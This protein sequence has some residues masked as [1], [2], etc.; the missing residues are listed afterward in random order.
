MALSKL[1]LSPSQNELLAELIQLDCSGSVPSDETSA[2][3]AVSSHPP[4]TPIVLRHIVIDGSN[5]AMS[6]GNNKT[7]SCRGIQL[8]VDYFK[9]RGHKEIT[10]FVPTYRKETPKPD[11]PVTGMAIIHSPKA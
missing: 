4:L 6:H 7:F 1:G 2:A 5:L 10:V 9:Q 3:G 11:D 8:A